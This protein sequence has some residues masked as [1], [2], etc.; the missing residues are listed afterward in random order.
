MKAKFCYWNNK[1]GKMID[2]EGEILHWGTSWDEVESGGR[3]YQYT[4][5]FIADS[6]GVVRE[7]IPTDM[8]I[9]PELPCIISTISIESTATQS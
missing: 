3:I 4:V 2:D 1:R 7:V 5:V 9:I 6:E 8:Q